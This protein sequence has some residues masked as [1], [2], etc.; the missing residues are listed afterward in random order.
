VPL[1]SILPRVHRELA[2]ADPLALREELTQRRAE[3]WKAAC[4]AERCRFMGRPRYPRHEPDPIDSTTTCGGYVGIR[5]YEQEPLPPHA[6]IVVW[7][8]R[9]C[10]RQLAW[11]EEQKALAIAERARYDAA[12]KHGP[13]GEPQKKHWKDE[14]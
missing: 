3:T 9:P 13:A 6:M 1:A 11:A 7:R 4:A 12:K 2:G 14:E 8:W 10:A 5:H